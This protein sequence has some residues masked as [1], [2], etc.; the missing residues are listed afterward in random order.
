M[1]KKILITVGY[2][3]RELDYICLLSVFL[4]KS[5]FDVKIIY[6]N[7]EVYHT[8]FSWHPDIV[9]LGQVNQNENIS[10]ARYAHKVGATVVILNC[11]G[12]YSKENSKVFFGININDFV[13]YYL[14][15]GRQQYLDINDL[16][17]IKETKVFQ[18]GTP[19]FDVYHPKILSFY[20]KKMPYQKQFNECKPT[21][22]IACSFLGAD[23]DWNMVK[24]NIAYK[25]I[26]KEIFEKQAVYQKQLRKSY[27]NLSKKISDTHLF[28]IIL[29]VHPLE[30]DFEY[31]KALVRQQNVYIDNS[32]PPV[33][34]F[35]A[36][37][38]LIHRTSTLA[39][40]AWIANI[41]TISFDPILNS[42]NGMLEFT[43]F[44]RKFSNQ[45]DVVK[46]IKLNKNKF[47]SKIISEQ[48]SFLKNRYGVDK[49]NAQFSSEKITAIIS[50]IKLKPKQRVWHFNIVLYYLFEVLKMILN[51][52]YNFQVIGLF[53]GQNYRSNMKQL[54]ITEAEV[55]KKI[56]FYQRLLFLN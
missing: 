6:A 21:I 1:K 49:N 33:R 4:Q 37:N 14:V 16:T 54:F 38:L 50:S 31:R 24:N 28:N 43:K 45:F 20:H 25:D 53:K 51:L 22:C 5:D 19:K 52:S 12:S 29:R 3:K 30:N 9:L 39:I 40:E 11:E 23:S 56:N 27:I 46:F 48:R 44:E 2:K 8:I 47:V 7:Y 41:P 34:L 36:I 15:W 42:D 55:N 18:C 26:S 35:S 17:N 10:V 32:I 13:D